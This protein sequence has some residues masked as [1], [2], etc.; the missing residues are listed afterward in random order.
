[1]SDSS[2]SRDKLRSIKDPPLRPAGGAQ[3]IEVDPAA[4]LKVWA[5]TADIFK[6]SLDGM[7]QNSREMQS[8]RQEMERVLVDNVVT[9][10]VSRNTRLIVLASCAATVLMTVW[11]TNEVRRTANGAREQVAALVEKQTKMVER[12]TAEARK[13]ARETRRIAVAVG[14]KADHLASLQAAI[15]G[16]EMAEQEAQHAYG[17]EGV[18]KRAKA[19]Q[20]RAQA[21]AKVEALSG[22][23]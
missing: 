8:V 3:K 2:R 15:S 10:R 13:E 19:E 7:D 21:K 5:D 1:M 12:N 17:V 23:L 9:R 14:K 18:E 22:E 11:T 16:A 6:E 4:M 20:R